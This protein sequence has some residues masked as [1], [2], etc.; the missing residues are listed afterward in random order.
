MNDTDRTLFTEAI[1]IVDNAATT[2]RN[3]EREAA[4]ALHD[5]HD[6]HAYR[7]AMAEKAECLVKMSEEASAA[8]KGIPE[9]T[10]VVSQ[11]LR[12]GQNANQALDLDSVFYMSALLYPE[13][14]VEG[15]KNDLERF[16]DTMRSYV[17]V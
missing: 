10:R 15:D 5:N 9:A 8:L 12:F 1:T 16:A 14:Y 7:I 2:I 17:N 3:V 13:D 4:V 6:E 11:L